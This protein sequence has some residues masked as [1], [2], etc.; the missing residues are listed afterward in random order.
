MAEKQCDLLKNGG[1]RN[2][3]TLSE[4]I[5][6]MGVSEHAITLPDDCDEVLVQIVV[7][8]S[9]ANRIYAQTLPISCLDNTKKQISLGGGYITSSSYSY[10]YIYLSKSVVQIIDCNISGQNYS[11]TSICRIYTR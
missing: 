6:N 8:L 11:G 9:N 4:N 2:K 1:G 7:P 10:V 5:S 3:W